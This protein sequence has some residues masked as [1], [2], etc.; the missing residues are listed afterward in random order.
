[1]SF[2][3]LAVNISTSLAIALSFWNEWVKWGCMFSSLFY[4]E[5]RTS[6]HSIWLLN[7][8]IMHW[9]IN[10]LIE[11]VVSFKYRV[12]RMSDTQQSTFLNTIVWS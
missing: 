1:M 6:A 11:E 12:Q 7:G 4:I 10:Y 2:S 9:S 3:L 5:N 8:I